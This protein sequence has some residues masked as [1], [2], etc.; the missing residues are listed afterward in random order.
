LNPP[1][2]VNGLR[3]EADVRHHR[4]ARVHARAQ[5]R[6]HPHTA[7]ELH[8][9]RPALL[10]EAPR[11]A[12]RLP[13][14]DLIRQER[15]IRD[16]QRA[17]HAAHHA[18]R[19]INHLLQRDRQRC[20]V[21]LHHHADGIAHEDRVGPG[22]VA[23]TCGCVVVGRDDGEL[24][25]FGFRG[26]KFGDRDLSERSDGTHWEFSVKRRSVGTASLY[27]VGFHPRSR[28]LR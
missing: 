14:A 1:Q 24:R 15:Q 18:P 4:N 19:V 26:A 7:F 11:V 5:C 17:P 9:V 27:R 3:R 13:R 20:R 23:Q 28:Y 22:F 25:P 10:N 8:R 16:D 21:S 12:N 2:L 6:V